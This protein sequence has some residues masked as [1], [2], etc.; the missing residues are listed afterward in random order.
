[1]QGQSY[2][3]QIL[4]QFVPVVACCHWRQSHAQWCAVQ[5][6]GKGRPSSPCWQ[7]Q[8]PCQLSCRAAQGR[9][10]DVALGVTCLAVQG[11]L[12]DVA[13]GVTWIAVQGRL[14]DVALGVTWIAVQSRLPDVAL[15]VTFADRMRPPAAGLRAMLLQGSAHCLAHARS[16]WT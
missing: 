16:L 14:P 1:M 8:R 3:Q 6:W 4:A 2:R 12:P 5:W 10:P 7:V 9:L 11:R 15:G 13:L